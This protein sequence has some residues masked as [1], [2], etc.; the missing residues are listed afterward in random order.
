MTAN[1]LGTELENFW[2]KWQK[3]RMMADELVE[4]FTKNECTSSYW[5]LKRESA[6]ME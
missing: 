3:W 6:G 5:P 1:S 4:L 2:Q